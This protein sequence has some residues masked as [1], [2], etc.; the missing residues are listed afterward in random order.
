MSGSFCH[1]S[2]IHL[3][4]AVTAV[5]QVWSVA[6]QR[7]HQNWPTGTLAVIVASPS[8]PRNVFRCRGNALSVSC[9]VQP[10]RSETA[11]QETANVPDS[12]PISFSS[13]EGSIT[14]IRREY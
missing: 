5:F 4:A 14:L 10:E 8:E 13:S 6:P 3:P 2:F 12:D 9:S 1:G 11:K 7:E